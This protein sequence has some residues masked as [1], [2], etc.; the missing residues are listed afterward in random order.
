MEEKINLKDKRRAD[1]V[2]NNP[3][4]LFGEC[5]TFTIFY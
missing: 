3:S 5:N 2:F 1:I 4:S